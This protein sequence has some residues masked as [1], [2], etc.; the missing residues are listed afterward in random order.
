MMLL[1]KLSIFFNPCINSNNNNNNSLRNVLINN[2][3]AKVID[4]CGPQ[5]RGHF[6]PRDFLKSDTRYSNIFHNQSI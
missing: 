5:T 2:K 3:Y 6:R 4:F 1:N